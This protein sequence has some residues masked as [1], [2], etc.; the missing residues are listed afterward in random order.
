MTS[1]SFP[2]TLGSTNACVVRAKT[3]VEPGAADRA[4]RFADRRRKMRGSIIVEFALGSALVLVIFAGVLQFGYSFFIYNSLQSSVRD[5]ARY[6]SLRPYDLPTGQE[7]QA[8][9]KN[10]ALYG[11]PA[12]DGSGAP[13]IPHLGLAHITVTSTPAGTVPE[14]VSV[15]ID[16][17]TIDM[18]FKKLELNGNPRATFRFMG[19]VVNP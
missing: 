18:F 1:S 7:W 15:Q 5:A 12:A 9:V 3:S 13:M 2:Q 19:R 10:M 16:G 4:H 8:A 14:D 11:D 6:A 17:V